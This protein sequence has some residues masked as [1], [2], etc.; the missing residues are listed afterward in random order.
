M[1]EAMSGEI[2]THGHHESVL[3]SHRWRTAENSCGYLLPHLRTGDR[4]LDV[5][6]GPGTITTDLASRV[7][8][9]EV[10]GVDVAE[11]VVAEAAR[12]AA[13]CGNVSFARGDAY[14][15][16]AAAGSFDVVHAHQVLQHLGDPIAGLREMRRVLRP[17]GLLAVRDSDYGAFVWAPADD[18][19]DRWMQLYHRITER[20]GAQ[21]D[22]GRWLPA[23]VAAAGFAAPTVSSSTWTFAAAADR[24]WWGQL[25]ADRVRRSSFATQAKEYGLSDDAELDELAAAFESWAREPAGVFVVVHV[26]V[27]ARAPS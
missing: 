19:L 17:G 21:A 23:W 16:D 27:L 12:S 26:E 3:R 22:A 11:D 25:W 7:A 24:S 8:P 15:I 6:C 1:T 2:Y 20:N 13:G 5:G 9:G 4:L 18:R 10:L 14:G